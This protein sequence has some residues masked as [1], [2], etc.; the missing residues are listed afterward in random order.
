M[1]G[2]MGGWAG[3]DGSLILDPLTN[4]CYDRVPPDFSRG[5]LYLKGRHLYP[6]RLALTEKNTVAI[7]R[8]TYSTNHVPNTLGFPIIKR[9]LLAD[10]LY[11][12]LPSS[13][14]GAPPTRSVLESYLKTVRS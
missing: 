5:L 12:F 4:V 7:R 8:P 13:F 3:V 14:R 9:L 11:Y 6:K 1:G 2:R 10:K